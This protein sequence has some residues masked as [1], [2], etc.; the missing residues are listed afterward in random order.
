MQF[1]DNLN[2]VSEKGKVNYSLQEIF[3]YFKIC[4]QPV[5]TLYMA[6]FFKTIL[7]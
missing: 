5:S 3:R 2:K 1:E 4:Q 6:A 7:R